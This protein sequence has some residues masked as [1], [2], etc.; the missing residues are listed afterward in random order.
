MTNAHKH[1][2][3]AAITIELRYEPDS[4]VVEVANDPPPEATDTGR[5][6]V[7]GGQGLPGLGERTRLIGGTVHARPTAAGGFRL[8]GVLPYTSPEGGI[9]SP[10]PGDATAT[11]VDPTCDL[12]GQIPAGF[13][14]EGDPVIDGMALPK[15]LARAMSTRR[16]GRGIAIGCGVVAVIGVLLVITPVIGG[17]F[18]MDEF[19]K[20]TIEPHQYDELRVGQ[21]ETEVR[22]QLPEGD[23]VLTDGLDKGAPP[24]PEGAKCLSLN[25]SESGSRLD[26]SPVFRFCFRDGE[27]IEKKSFEVEDA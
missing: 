19:D 11:F 20:A 24:V 18:L 22:K 13:L 25:S 26:M 15:E 9:P 6:V 8:A 27:L 14:G 4:L 3:G 5:S 7:S 1:A 16:R 10:S 21:S 17:F 2:P 12:R 23:S